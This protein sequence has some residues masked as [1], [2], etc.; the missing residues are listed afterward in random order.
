MLSRKVHIVGQGLAGSMLTMELLHRGFDVSISDDGHLSSSSMVAAGMWN[1]VTFKKLSESWMASQLLIAADQTYRRLES[2]LGIGFYHPVELVRLFQNNLAANDWEEKSVH[3]ELSAYLSD[4][5]DETFAKEFD[6]PYGHG[7]VTGAGWLDI[8]KFL[9]GLRD[10]FMDLGIY[11][12]RSSDEMQEL[13]QNPHVVD[14]TIFCTGWRAV[15]RG[16]FD[17]APIIPNKG[18]V[19][20]VDIPE[21]SINRMVN[22][23]NFI[24]PIGE[25]RFRFGATYKLNE[26]DPNPQK[27]TAIEMIS[28]LREIYHGDVS[29]VDHKAGYRPTT[30][31][32]KP[33]IGEHPEHPGICIF[34]GFGSKGVLLIP[35][36][37]NHFA[38]VLTGNIELMPDVNVGRYWNRTVQSHASLVSSFREDH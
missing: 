10:Y 27:E 7:V 28:G 35:Y 5:R 11:Q 1:P 25:N 3:P 23:G 12:V 19:L 24:V 21:L 2:K 38:E 30:P 29:L 26:P 13:N 18:E 8:P 36:F 14:I 34:N 9:N 31:D 22:F 33:L 32:R 4:L 16:L 20:T 17:W 37:A 15:N 6:Q